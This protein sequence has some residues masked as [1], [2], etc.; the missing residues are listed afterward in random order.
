MMKSLISGLQFAHEN[1][2]V[3]CDFNSDNILVNCN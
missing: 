2:M 1:K 3:H